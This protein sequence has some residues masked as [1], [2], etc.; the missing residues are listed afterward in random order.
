MP[1]STSTTIRLTVAKVGARR[2]QLRDDR[3]KTLDT[4]DTRMAALDLINAMKRECN[5]GWRI[6]VSWLNCEA[7]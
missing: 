4:V 2:Y 1:K 3:G 7:P 6:E 5:P